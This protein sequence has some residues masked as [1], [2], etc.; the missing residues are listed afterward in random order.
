MKQLKYFVLICSLLIVTGVLHSGALGADSV[1]V[2]F[3][4]N[5]SGVSSVTLP[6]EFNNWNNQAAPMQFA[7]GDLWIRTERLAIGGNPNPPPNGIPGAWQYKFYYPGASPWPNDPLN[8]HVNPKD[9]NN[10]YLYVEDPTIYHLIPNQRMDIVTTSFPT[11]SAYIFPKVGSVVDTSALTLIID[12]TTYTGIGSHYNFS[13]KQ[14]TFIPPAP[15]ADGGHVV[16][17]DVGTN[18]DTV[19]FTIVTSAPPVKPLPAY[20]QPGVTLPSPASN[21]STSFCLKVG[22]TSSVLLRVAPAGQSVSGSIPYIMRKDSTSDIWWLNLYLPPGSYEYLYQTDSGGLFYDPWGR[23]NGEFGSR[24]TIG[25]E[26][27]TADDYVWQSTNYQKPPLNQLIVY[28]MHV[29]EFAGG[30]YG[31]GPGEAGF[32]ELTTLIP[33]F[34]SLGVNA[35]ELMPINDFGSIG[36]SG[37]SWGYNI[38]SYFALEPGYGTPR[39]FKVLV[40]SAHARGIAI[41]VDV[42]FNHM[43][44]EGGL[45]KMQ[46]DEVSNPYFKPQTVLNYN[47]D[48]LF[49]FR[50]IDHWSDDTQELIYRVLKMWIDEY[51][52]DG[53]RYDFTQGIGWNINEPTKGILG[54]A[55]RIDQDYNGTIYQIAEHLPESPALIYYSG[56]TGGWHDS[57]HDEVFDDARF[58]NTTLNEYENLVLDLGAYPGN[59]TPPTPSSYANRTE[60]VN[61]NVTHDEQSLIYEMTTF[62]GVALSEAI[63]RDKLY[64]VFMFTSLGIPML[65]EGMEFSAPR[66]WQNSN[67]KLSYRPVEWDLLQTPRGQE[68][69]HYYRSLILQRRFNPALYEGT[70]HKLYKYNS[71]KVLVWGFDHPT[72]P[73]KVMIA[74][75]LSGI[76]QTI[77]NVPWLDT[78]DWYDIF[79]QS[80]LTVNSTPLPTLTIPAYTALVYSNTPDSV[81]SIEQK[82]ESGLPRQFALYPNYPNPFNPQTRIHFELPTTEQVSMVIV[83]ILGQKVKT[84]IN[85]TYPAGKYEVIWDGTGDGGQQLSS[86][87]YIL[88]F[89]AGNYVKNHR[90]VLMK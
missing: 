85:R 9:Y 42:V 19:N 90:M 13:T 8:H 55:N 79:D 36:A 20:V 62:Q 16:I 22:G 25:P 45:W 74:S 53:F 34:D 89:R 41:I 29:G 88:H 49:F 76:E 54:W 32:S 43:T 1:D 69:Y 67:E 18:S 12:T 82:G 87:I 77:S 37:H 28:E 7:G 10:S 71:Q 47:E 72:L 66:G 59:D 78:G 68:H 23:W 35:I 5:K 56:L 33:Y 83:N 61:A 30:Y 27:L 70:L 58:K 21:D 86:G 52:V 11:I 46:P 40:D 80:V 4:Y 14:L 39:E 75:N 57:F 2:T 15:L 60:P 84:L 44:D 73:H 17:L 26:G 65:W 63:Q 50:D 38:N 6:G 64:A 3:R 48:P 31:L 81:L 51:R 24:F